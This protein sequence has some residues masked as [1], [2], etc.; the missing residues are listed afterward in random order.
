MADLVKLVLVTGHDNALFMLGA[1]QSIYTSDMKL[2]LGDEMPIRS[3]RKNSE[4]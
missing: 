1:V 4:K 3:H 2:L